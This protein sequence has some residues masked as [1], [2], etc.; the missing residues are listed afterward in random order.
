MN[1]CFAYTRVSTVKQGEGVSLQEQRAAIEAYAQRQRIDITEWFEERITAAKQGRPL[2]TSMLKKLRQGKARGV[3]IHKIDRSARNLRDWAELGELIDAGVTVH[4]ANEN[5]D[6]LSRG[7]RL[8]ADIQAVV[9]A[10]YV[11]NLREECLKGIRGRLKQGLYPFA[12]PLGYLDT[13]A[14][15]PKAI[16]PA[17]GP[18]IKD[19]FELYASGGYTLDTLVV[20]LGERGLRNRS[21]GRVSRA[22][23]SK[24]LNNPFYTGLIRIKTT[25]ESYTGVHTPLVPMALF[26][27]VQRRLAGRIRATGWTHDFLFRG[28][29][30]CS[31]C[32][33]YLSAERQKGH[34]YYR[35]HTKDCPTKTFREEVLEN[36]ILE[37]WPTL[38]TTAEEKQLLAERLALVEQQDGQDRLDRA[39][40][41]QAR[42]ASTK[43]RQNRLVDALLDGVLDKESFEER[44][45]SLLEEE[46][47][48]NDALE[49]KSQSGSSN[50]RILLDVFELAS[51]A[52][53]SYFLADS[54]S[55]R[56]LVAKLSSN[57]TVAGHKVSVRPYFPLTVL[58]ARRSVSTGTHHSTA[59][60]TDMRAV[61]RLW[62]WLRR[63]KKT[64]RQT[65]LA[66]GAQVMRQPERLPL[67]LQ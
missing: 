7:G 52:Q 14:G 54:A 53:Q 28:L 67:L 21:D 63:W 45:R 36:A 37:T 11:R 16:D 25:G 58:A 29:F 22:G 39:A 64:G 10:D 32:D 34:T 47:S 40:I 9:A 13:G 19:A 38:A 41:L 5:I 18:L 62:S 59:I 43:E 48:L 51:T 3:V 50:G 61:W 35:C 24:I 12:A 23:L 17:R 1:Q 20:A 26:Q 31:L 30:R 42:L 49:A 4:F 8:S 65:R 33:R 55:R 15:K 46:R 56:E 57:L 66:R 6:L 27:R 44:K 2:F 60:R